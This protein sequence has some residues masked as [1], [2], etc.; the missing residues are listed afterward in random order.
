[1]QPTLRSFDS[2]NVVVVIA[3]NKLDKLGWE[4]LERKLAPVAW[5][6]RFRLVVDCF[7]G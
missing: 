2:T 5:R 4:E 7:Q 1:M 6:I 3:G